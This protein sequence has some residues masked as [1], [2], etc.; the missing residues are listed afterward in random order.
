MS[1]PPRAAPRDALRGQTPP[2][3]PYTLFWVFVLTAFLGAAA[4][5]GFMLLTRG[6]LQ[7]R[8]S[9]LYGQLS[10]VW[11]LGGV[12]FTLLLHRLRRRGPG[13]VFL[14][15]ALAGSACEYLCSWFQEAAFGLNFWDYRHLPLNVDGRVNLLFSLFWGGAAL[16]WAQGLLGPLCRRLGARPGRRRQTVT[17][18][19]ALALV[20]DAALTGAALARM[21]QRR[22]GLEP[23]TAVERFLDRTYPDGRLEGRFP[24][25][26]YIGTPEARRA[27]GMD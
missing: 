9:L 23:H 4:E 19:V 22:H 15:G 3:G 12:L 20:C 7:N 2:P 11:G 16:L 13:P 5:T 21:D 26:T 27:A 14:A 10:L 18:L 25:L 17:A 6:Q 24:T 8:S 1:P